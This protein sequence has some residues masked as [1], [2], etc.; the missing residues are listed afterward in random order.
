VIVRSLTVQTY[1]NNVNSTKLSIHFNQNWVYESH[2]FQ[3]SLFMLILLFV[4]ILGVYIY[5]VS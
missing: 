1:T 5:L 4:S 3:Y 2:L